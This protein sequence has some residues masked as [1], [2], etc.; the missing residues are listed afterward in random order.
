MITDKKNLRGSYFV[1]KTAAIRRAVME[2]L[3]ELGYGNII[4]HIDEDIIYVNERLH[5]GQEYYDVK[6]NEDVKRVMYVKLEPG[7]IIT[8]EE[9]EFQQRRINMEAL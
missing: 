9:I 2:K 6:F 7:D 4:F 3:K 8:R 5:I 1:V